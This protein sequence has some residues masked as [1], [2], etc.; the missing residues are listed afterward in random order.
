MQLLHRGSTGTEL[1]RAGVGRVARRRPDRSNRQSARSPLLTG[2][3]MASVVPSGQDRH[4]GIERCP[5]CFSAPT[6]ATA[7]GVVAAGI[8][9]VASDVVC[10]GTAAIAGWVRGNLGH[11]T[12][13]VNP[14][15][16]GGFANRLLLAVAQDPAFAFAIVG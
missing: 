14:F 7:A 1:R 12:P 4:T 13:A 5:R 16:P 2:A 6:A 15:K 8:C 10:R 3:L 9:V 11:T